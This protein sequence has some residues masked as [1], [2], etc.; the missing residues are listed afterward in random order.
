[1]SEWAANCHRSVAWLT[2]DEGDQTTAGFLGYLIS[3][4]QT[5]PPALGEAEAAALHFSQNPPIEVLLVNLLNE[6]AAEPDPFLLVLDDYHLVDSREIDRLMAFFVEHQPGQI[7]LVILTREDPSLPLTRLR[8][9]NQLTEIRASD[10]RF[11]TAETADFMNQ[12]MGINLKSEEIIKLDGQVEGWVAG[13]QLAGLALQGQKTPTLLSKPFTGSNHFVLD[14]LLDEVL[15][16]QDGPTQHFLIQTSIL[17]RL[18]GSLCDAITHNDS[19]N[20]QQMLETLEHANL[21][22]IPLDNERGW[23]RYHPLFRDLL[24]KQLGQRLSNDAISG[25]HEQA[26]QWFEE[27]DEPEKAIQHA[28]SGKTFERAV[29]LAEASYASMDEAFR[30]A[31]WLAWVNKLPDQVVRKHP[32]LCIQMAMSLTDS[33]NLELSER[34]L[35]Y[36]DPMLS[37]TNAEG[38]VHLLAA[39]AA[40]AHAFNAQLL[41]N[42]DETVRFANLSLQHTPKE[43]SFQR[44]QINVILGFTN[45]AN[46]NLEAALNTM[47]E[48]MSSMLKLGNVMFVVAS[49]FAV[50]DILVGLGRLEDAE[51]SLIHCLELAKTQGLDAENILAHHYLGLAMISHERNNETTFKKFLQ[52]AEET[53]NISTLPD[54]PYRYGLAQAVIYETEGDLERA[55]VA[56]DK[57]QTNYTVNPVPI[58]RTTNAL[59]ARIHIKQ[60]RLNKAHDWVQ[61]QRLSISDDVT[62]LSE[63]D[64]LTL[65]RLHIQEGD[66]SGVSDMLGRMLIAAKAQNRKGSLLEILTTMS[67]INDA[68]GN[69]TQALNVIEQALTLAEPESYCRLFIECGEPMRKMLET[70]SINQKHPLKRYVN[71]LLTAFSE[72]KNKTSPSFG[73]SV[74]VEPLTDREIEI[75]RLIA[76]GFSNEEISRQLYV[77]ISTIKGHNLRIFDKLQVKNRTEAVAKARE[78]GL[79]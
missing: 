53:G 27:H 59:K 63:F 61:K 75:L 3:A 19:Y 16:H 40:L 62:Y 46:G 42:L 9:R 58:L 76:Q 39:K 55:L 13:L 18:C 68:Q 30:S 5:I 4:L 41:G 47:N 78:I 69:T 14:Y 2:L 56:L 79:I 50:A 1:M 17:D 31:A 25:L 54:W 37:Q 8:A 67:L 73:A 77:V 66:F 49:G 15:T 65:A 74:L 57:A 70:L 33:G 32:L 29:M 43:D 60:N 6:I 35:Q 36:A 64:H 45:W 11:N 52:K 34:Y 26:S 72:V 71:N 44:S 28:I 20:S 7:H 23:F 24:Q 12:V 51:K 38:E 48:W 10:L 21:F 22:I